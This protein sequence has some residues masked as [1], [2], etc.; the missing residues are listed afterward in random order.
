MPVFL[1]LHVLLLGEELQFGPVL[2]LRL[3]SAFALSS[4]EPLVCL[5]LLLNNYAPFVLRL[6]T[7]HFFIK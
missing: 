2:V 1:D 5:G 4:F 7:I 3:R 6:V